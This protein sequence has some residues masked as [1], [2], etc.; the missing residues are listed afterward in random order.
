MAKI[1]F[2]LFVR[3][4]LPFHK[5]LSERLAWLRVFAKFA[6]DE[7]TIFTDIRKQAMYLF[8]VNN[9]V[10]I[11]ENYLNNTFD[12]E[13]RRIRILHYLYAGNVFS[14]STEENLSSKIFGLKSENIGVAFGLKNE[15][16]VKTSVDYK[17]SAPT[18]IS[19]NKIISELE[20]YRPAG[21]TYEIE[22]ITY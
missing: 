1:W 3:L 2:N 9:Q 16:L 5:R 17:I 18:T 10:I 6:D 7:M 22:L 8:T 13:L 20:K 4:F 19:A 21:K 12:N 14:L 15:G 11:L